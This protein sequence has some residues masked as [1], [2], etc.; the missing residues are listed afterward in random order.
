M[1]EIEK[2]NQMIAEF[3]NCIIKKM[4]DTLHGHAI[5]A[6]P[7]TKYYEFPEEDYKGYRV[8]FLKYHSSW[9]WLMPVVEKIVPPHGQVL[10]G[11]KYQTAVVDALGTARIEKVYDVVVEFIRWHNEN[12]KKEGVD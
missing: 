3:M 2:N 8:E 11:I 9:N 5:Y 4:G 12:V 10:D 7:T 1:S 6:I